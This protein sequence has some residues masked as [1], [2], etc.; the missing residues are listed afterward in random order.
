MK[1]AYIDY[2]IT[3][4]QRPPSVASFVESLEAGQRPEDF[5][6]T[7]ASFSQL[8]AQLFLETF[9]GTRNQLLQDDIYQAYN[10][11]EKL[12]AVFFTLL[13]ELAPR[14]AFWQAVFQAEPFWTCLS[15]TEET[16]PSFEA[17]M[18]VIIE[19]GQEVGIVASRNL[20]DWYPPSLWNALRYVIYTWL[21]DDTENLEHTDAAVEKTVNFAFDVMEPNLLDSGFDL[22]KFMIQGKPEGNTE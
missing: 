13:E 9:E 8:E 17:L 22:L 11:R 20:S 7:Y 2:L 14:R 4:G 3:H 5:F 6:E 18:Q 12:L 19:E 16:K 10:P 1:Q 21:R 15:F